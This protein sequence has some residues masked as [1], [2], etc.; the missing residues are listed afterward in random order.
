M[1]LLARSLRSIVRNDAMRDD[2]DAIYNGRTIALVCCACFGG[3]LFGWDSGTIGG[4]LAMDQTSEKFGYK[5]RSKTDKSNLDQNIVSTLQAGCFAACLVTSWF[6]DRFGRRTTLVGA[7]FL[8]TIGVVF[9]AASGVNGTLAVMYVGRFIGG[10]GAGCASTVTPLYVSECCPRAIRGGLTAFYQLFIVSGI[11]VAFWINYGCLL[12]LK[13][14]AVYIV[15]LALQAVPAI[16][17][18]SSLPAE[19]EYVSQEIREMAEQLQHERRL[20]GD[21][22]FRSLMR[23][24]WLVPAN[25]KRAVITVVLMCCQQLTGVNAINYYAPQIFANLGMTGTDS[26]L[27]ATGVYGIVKTVACML[28]LLLIADS[29]GRRRSLLWTSPMLTVV[30]FIIGIYGRVQPPVEGNPVTAFGYVAIICIYLWAAFFQFGWGP[31]CWILI[32]EIPTARL[33]AVNVSVGAATQ[34]LFN[35]VMAR[36]VLTMQ[37]TMGYK[38]YK[39]SLQGMFFMFGSF[40]F[41]MGVFVYLFVPETKGLS[42]ERMDELFGMTDL[43]EKQLHA[44]GPLEE[45]RQMSSVHGAERGTW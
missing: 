20:M 1:G 6:A 42:L 3:M 28:F 29:L 26:S 17:R 13:A 16:L 15:P 30:L 22:N 45:G 41:L 8:T 21:A 11:M 44:R 36:T 19:S 18:K 7:G 31:A 39:S 12:H 5:N 27:F 4:V 23:E 9:Q 32:S 2:P 33:R 43:D 10:L 25:R 40:D 38:G 24:M 34:W 14:P 35:F 37:N